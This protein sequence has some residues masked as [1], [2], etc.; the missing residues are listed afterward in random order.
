MRGC[1]NYCSYCIVPYVRGLEKS[2][3]VEEIISEI[4]CLTHQGVK[5]VTLL[6]QNVNSYQFKIENEK[7]KIMGFADLLE[8][9]NKIEGLERIRF[10]TSHPKDLNEKTIYAIRD[11]DKVCE[12]IHLPVQAGSN[13][14][15]KMMNRKYSRED[16]I[17]LAEKIRET[18]P[19]IAIT[20]DLIVGFPGETEQDFQD[21]LDLVKEVEFDSAYTFKYS[22]RPGTTAAKLKDDVPLEIKKQRLKILNETCNEISCKKNKKLTATEQEVLI[23]KNSSHFTGKQIEKLEGRTRTNKIVFIQRKE[24]LVGK[25]VNVEI[26]EAYPHSLI[27]EIKC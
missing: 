18:I 14:V 1:E 10:V 5:E 27:G 2:R 15:L 24:N 11:L 20:T 4:N 13:K 8:E 9:V 25:T 7:L 6:G 21:T 22:P 19:D 3:P 26:V 17:V 16:Y 23:E 12:H